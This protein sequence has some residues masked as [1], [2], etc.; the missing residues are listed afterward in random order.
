[1]VLAIP[2]VVVLVPVVALLLFAF[3]NWRALGDFVAQFFRGIPVVGGQI[4]DAIVAVAAAVGQFW[5]TRL[6]PALQPVIDTIDFVAGIPTWI[7]RTATGAATW[8]YVQVVGLAYTL[9]TLSGWAHG[10]I[11]GI[12][13]RIAA[14]AA[15]IA[16]LQARA[17]ALAASIANIIASRIPAAI[18]AAVA[19]ASAYARGLVAAAVASLTLAVQAARAAALAAVGQE[20]AARQAAD[21][22]LRAAAAAEAAAVGR[23]AAAATAAVAA[24]ASA[25]ILDLE[26]NVAGL[27]EKVGPVAVGTTIA[28]TIA[29]T[30]AE[31]ERLRRCSDPICSYLSPQLDALNALLDVGTAVLLAE[32]V[33][34]AVHDPK[35]TAGTVIEA[36]D[37]L[38]A[39]ARGLYGTIVGA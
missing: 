13:T 22:A 35:G 14:A 23:Q 32:L 31:L 17:A 11:A 36:A 3:V 37:P 4:H 5:T 18:A 30:E 2:A 33:A 7:V 39:G 25:G 29:A 9:S 1:M 16:T 10:Q 20:V 6:E 19:Q 15:S 28:A 26:R 8:V 34:S 12:L 38:I 27:A 24:S 21:A